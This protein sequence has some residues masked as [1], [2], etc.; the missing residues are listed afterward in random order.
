MVRIVKDAGLVRVP[1]DLDIPH[2]AP[3][4]DRLENAITPRSR[5]FVATHLFGARLDFDQLF[6]LA[7]HH[8][9]VAVEDCAQ[10][11][12]GKAYPGS[13]EADVNMF[14]FGPIKTATALGGAL[15]RVKD[16]RLR[17]RMRAL[18]STYPVQSDRRQLKRVLQFM[19]LKVIMSPAVLGVICSYYNARGVGYCPN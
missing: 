13:D 12:N 9:I 1:V 14:S 17:E 8:G 15:I 4:L 10:A 7:R 5:I 11:F 19:A 18:Q 6:A 16:A 2:M 3:S